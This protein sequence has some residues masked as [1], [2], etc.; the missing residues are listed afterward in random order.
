MQNQIQENNKQKYVRTKPV[1]RN[2]MYVENDYGVIEV[3]SPKYGFFRFLIDLDDFE[4]CSNLTWGIM[5]AKSIVSDYVQYYASTQG[6]PEYK[7][8]QL[9]LHRF[10]MNTPKGMLTDHING[11]SYD[12]RKSNLRICTHLEN[13]QNRAKNKNNTSG[14]KGVSWNTKENKWGAYIYLNNKYKNLGLYETIEAATEV[15]R[16]AEEKYFGEFN[17]Q[18]EYQ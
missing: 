15:R 16:L 13:L 2:I 4:K 14:V 3:N 9:L 10:L 5:A 6:H 18:L 17:R 11:N 1:I 8:T 7:G 12:N